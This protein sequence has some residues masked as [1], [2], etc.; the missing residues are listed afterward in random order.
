MRKKRKIVT[1][2]YQI[3]I[4]L[5]LLRLLNPGTTKYRH[6][7]PMRSPQLGRRPRIPKRPTPTS[8]RVFVFHAR[9]INLIPSREGIITWIIMRFSAFISYARR[10][11]TTITGTSLTSVRSDMALKLIRTRE[12]SCPIMLL[13]WS[14]Y[15][16]TKISLRM[17]WIS[18][19]IRT[20][21]CIS[22]SRI[23]APVGIFEK[24]RK[25]GPRSMT[26]LAVIS[27]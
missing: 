22:W 25:L 20:R 19:R 8:M 10:Q 16:R 21:C 26:P 1:D 6:I 27:L 9:K 11:G 23:L 5:I 17:I 4:G 2:T 13:M 3:K 14:S 24:S 18:P 7:S 15:A 12:E